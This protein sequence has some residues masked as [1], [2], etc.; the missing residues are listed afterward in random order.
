MVAHLFVW[1]FITFL[2]PAVLRLESAKNT[3]KYK[4]WGQLSSV[5]VLADGL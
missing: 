5:N 1:C 2:H 3:F 4:E